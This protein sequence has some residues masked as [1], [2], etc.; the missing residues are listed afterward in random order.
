M[1]KMHIRIGKDGKTAI[2]VEGGKREDCVEFTALVEK[3]VGVVEKRE[4]TE[5]YHQSES[6]DLNDNIS[7]SETL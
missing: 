7:E 5:E 3:A 1:K 6:I 4:F 2:R